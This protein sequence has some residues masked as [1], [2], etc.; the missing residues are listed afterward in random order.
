MTEVRVNF[1]SESF[2]IGPH[3]VSP[4]LV[5]APLHEITDRPFRRMIWE[6]GGVGLTV[7]EMISCE[8][9]IRRARKAEAMMAL[10]GGRPF[11]MQV[12]GSVPEHLAEAARMCEA[13]G[14][15]L[16]DLNMGCPAGNVTRG[17]SGSALMRDFR[18][19]ESCVRAIVGAVKVPVT[20]KMRAGWDAG[21]K[22]RGEYL[23]FL[24]MFEAA[25]VQ[26]LT[27]HPRTRTQQYTG[28][29]DWSLIARAVEAGMSYPIIGNGD[30]LEAADAHRMVRETG[31]Q[32][33][34]IGRGVLYNP[35]LFRQVMDPGL[36]V[37]PGMRID[38][39]LR[40]FR[41][42]LESLE[43]REALHRIKKIGGW[44]TKGLPG[45]AKFRQRLNERNDPEELI[46]EIEELRQG[47]AHGEP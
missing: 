40:F 16:V 42:L 19:A 14:A 15:D 38:L 25:G 35:F 17:G 32:G 31:C 45:G 36:E 12:V 44:F 27:L 34:M 41:I 8:A 28:Q 30:V 47:G 13:A 26:A 4:P 10:D 5:L 33:V 20:V 24:R 18:L 29:A 11:A 2:S 39:T 46:R 6:L 37:T 22:E 43:E 7:S 3:R 21:Q 9:L 23:D 1:P